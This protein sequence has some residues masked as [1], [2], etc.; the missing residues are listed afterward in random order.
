[1]LLKMGY[2]VIQS[3]GEHQESLGKL[4]DKAPPGDASSVSDLQPSP[5]RALIWKRL[6]WAPGSFPIAPL[7]ATC[8]FIS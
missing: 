8:W 4:L 1:M 5:H 2:S 7:P 3:P 6:A